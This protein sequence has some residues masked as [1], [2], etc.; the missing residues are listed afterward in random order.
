[1]KRPIR[2]LFL[3]L[4]CAL[5]PAAF[6]AAEDDPAASPD[7]AACAADGARIADLA[8][9]GDVRG[10]FRAL[11]ERTRSEFAA[12]AADAAGKVDA[13]TWEAVKGALKDVGG[14]F[15]AQA[16]LLYCLYREGREN[17][18]ERMVAD[19]P[20]SAMVLDG[21]SEET[22]SA[23]GKAVA[24]LAD[25][26]SRDELLAGRIDGVFAD[27]A[28]C[29]GL[30]RMFRSGF[31]AKGMKPAE[32]VFASR[33]DEDM[34][35]LKDLANGDEDPFVR[36]DGKWYPEELVVP[37]E[38]WIAEQRKA[39]ADVELTD[40]DA[41]GLRTLGRQVR[42]LVPG[43]RAAKTREEF[44]MYLFP[45]AMVVQGMAPDPESDAGL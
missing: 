19:D 27:E 10:L 1:M 25:G 11:P 24:G 23:F 28:L 13:E 33:S 41:R 30:G 2:S 32:Y 18:P 39:L 4:L 45:I 34:I 16:P 26:L 7:V 43:M 29:D 6:A 15:D 5:A 37:F 14:L 21:L 35:V 42:A 44:A 12:L 8:M 31:A 22:I 17:H 9:R 36:M 3:S 40:E 20:V 38:G